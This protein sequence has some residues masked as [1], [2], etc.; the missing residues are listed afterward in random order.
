M[1]GLATIRAAGFDPVF[2]ANWNVQFLRLVAIVIAEEKAEC[3]VRIGEPSLEGS[4]HTSAG[5]A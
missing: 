5:L 2:R 3:S 4:C 1:S